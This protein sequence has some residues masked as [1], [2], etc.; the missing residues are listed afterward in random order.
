MTEMVMCVNIQ[1]DW[2]LIRE[3]MKKRSKMAYKHYNMEDKLEALLN[4]CAESPT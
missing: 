2:A 1:L 4:N 3:P